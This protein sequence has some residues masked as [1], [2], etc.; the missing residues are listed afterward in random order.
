MKKIIFIFFLILSTTFL[1]GWGWKK[2][3]P[4]AFVF[5][6]D[7]MIT[8]SNVSAKMLKDV[9]DAGERINY[10]IFKKQTFETDQIRLQVIKV[11]PKYPFYKVEVAYTKDLEIDTNK[12]FLFDYFCIHQEGQYILRVFEYTDFDRPLVEGFFKVESDVYKLDGKE[13]KQ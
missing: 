7:Q 8:P 10:L 12:Y 6:S 11:E 1:L 3:E 5:L 2:K 4:K 9:Y 13:F